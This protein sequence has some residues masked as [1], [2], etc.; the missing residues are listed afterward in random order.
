MKAF[1]FYFVRVLLGVFALFCLKNAVISTAAVSFGCFSCLSALRESEMA[2]N[3]SEVSYCFCNNR[4]LDGD[5]LIGCE[6]CDRWFH[7][8]YSEVNSATTSHFLFSLCWY[9]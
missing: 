7:G 4:D 9:R 2:S 6:A 1:S 3:A 8:G 5:F